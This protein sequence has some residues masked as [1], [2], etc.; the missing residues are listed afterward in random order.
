VA[1]ETPESELKRLRTE[2]N[3]TRQDEVFGGLSPAERATTQ[4]HILVVDDN[5]DIRKA[6]CGLISTDSRLGTCQE[7]ENGLEAFQM[8]EKQH[9]DLV[10]MDMSMPVMNGIEAAKCIK[11]VVPAILIVLLSLHSDFLNPL[12]MSKMG[13]SALVSKYRASSDL[14]PTIR[15]LLSLPCPVAV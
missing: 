11:K 9:P 1:K 12:E 8:A 6:V 7:A 3:K 4:K 14:V 10:V 2:Q 5:K 15:S 13:I